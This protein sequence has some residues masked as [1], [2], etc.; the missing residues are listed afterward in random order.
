M[1]P[2][3]DLGKMLMIL[4]GIFVLLGLL[5]SLGPKLPWR[6]G[7]LPGDLFIR[8]DSFTLYFPIATSVLLSVVLTLLLLVFRRR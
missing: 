5:L 3:R 6:L 8:R 7:R 2:T 1:E 4:G